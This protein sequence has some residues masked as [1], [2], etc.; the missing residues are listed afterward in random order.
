VGNTGEGVMPTGKYIRSEETRRRMS[1]AHK[2]VPLSEENK[3]GISE[4]LKGN[5]NTKGMLLSDETK[6]K[7]SEALKGV[8]KSE[9]HKRKLSEANKGVLRSDETKRRISEAQKGRL[10]SDETKRK[11]SEIRKAQIA[12]NPDQG[13]C[14][15]N[16]RACQYFDFINRLTN[17]EGQHALNGGEKKILKYH[18]DYFNPDLKLIIEWNESRHYTETG[19]L[20]A[21]DLKR[22]QEIQAE[23]SDYKF[24]IEKG[25]L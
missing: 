5:T 10:H 23:Y 8:P 6:R 1:E 3:R 24:I 9:E 15:F 17:T 13:L 11:M 14:N 2:G 18:V 25:V 21:Y 20:R 22:Q 16:P 19:E 12:S 4:S 7:I